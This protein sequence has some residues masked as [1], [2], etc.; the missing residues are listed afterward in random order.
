MNKL[1]VK[2]EKY[3]DRN[4]CINDTVSRKKDENK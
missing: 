2:R 4:M 1:S 3:K